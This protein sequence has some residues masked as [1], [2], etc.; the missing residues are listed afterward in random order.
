[1]NRQQ[2]FVL[3]GLLAVVS[4]VLTLFWL[5]GSTG[6]SVSV[7]VATREIQP[8]TLVKAADLAL[9][10]VDAKT[11]ATLFPTAYKETRPLT[12]QIALRQIRANEVITQAVP[13]FAPQARMEQASREL[14]ISALVPEGY[15]AIS[16]TGAR[17]GA[18][19]GD[20]IYLFKNNPNPADLLMGGATPSITPVL[21]QP[22][23]VVGERSSGLV[24]LVAEEDVVA[25]LNAAA[26]GSVYAAVAPIGGERLA[27]DG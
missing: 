26:A 16:L 12:G 27:A 20:L 10:E 3:A 24:V 19:P 7:V 2:R 14:P 6:K 25:V 5:G 18:M 8:F 4:A 15:R 13:T 22:V 1:M 21:E 9:V 23:R 11:A 17:V